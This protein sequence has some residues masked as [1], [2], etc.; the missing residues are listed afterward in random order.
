MKPASVSLRKLRESQAYPSCPDCRVTIGTEWVSLKL[1]ITNC[2]GL[3][4]PPGSTETDLTSPPGSL[5]GD[6][7]QTSSSSFGIKQGSQCRTSNLDSLLLITEIH[8]D[9]RITIKSGA[10]N[11][12]PPRYSSIAGCGDKDPTRIE[13]PGIQSLFCSDRSN[14]ATLAHGCSVIESRELPGRAH[15]SHLDEI[16]ITNTVY[17]DSG[18]IDKKL[19]NDRANQLSSSETST[20]VIKPEVL[21]PKD[22]HHQCSNTPAGIHGNQLPKPSFL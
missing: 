10:G 2:D 22:I 5:A 13:D 17:F 7:P 9:S 15:I 4:D 21:P 1:Y 3:Q 20:V 18:S 14:P 11:F 16:V 19:R 8:D 12:H 6:I